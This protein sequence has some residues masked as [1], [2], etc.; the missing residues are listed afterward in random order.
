MDESDVCECVEIQRELREN[1]VKDV[2]SEDVSELSIIVI[3]S[4]G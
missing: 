2:S 1:L 4:S 3:V